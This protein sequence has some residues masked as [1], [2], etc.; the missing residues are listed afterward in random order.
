M[1]T[2]GD[3]H[4]GGQDF[5]NALVEHFA[6]DFEEKH[7][8]DLRQNAKAIRKLKVKCQSLKHALSQ[9]LEAQIEIDSLYNGIDYSAT[10]TRGKKYFF[11]FTLFFYFIFY[12]ILFFIL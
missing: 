8:E 5:D 6:S 11:M 4:L 7:G 3:T 2:S 10:I 1:S 9:S 12:F